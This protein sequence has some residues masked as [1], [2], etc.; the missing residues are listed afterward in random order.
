M[1]ILNRRWDPVTAMASAYLGMA[2]D[3]IQAQV[4]MFTKP[5]EEYKKAQAQNKSHKIEN[6]SRNKQSSEISDS[7]SLQG[8]NDATSRASSMH[9][10]NTYNKKSDTAGLMARA[11]GKS[12]GKMLVATGKG[13]F[14]DVPLAMADGM[15]AMP[16]L[17]GGKVRDYGKVTGW[18]SGMAVGGKAFGL[19]IVD[20][21][22]DLVV[23]PYK[24]GRKEG[25]LG[26]AK[27][28]GKGT[29]NMISKISGGAVGVWAYP[30]QGIA[31]SIS[32]AV[33]TTSKKEIEVAKREEGAWL[34]Q[35]GRLTDADMR[36]MIEAFNLLKR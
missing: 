35:E 15:R 27:G 20:G 5:Y 31:K 25:A 7:Q 22:A 8:G 21:L 29:V 6:E 19:G 11:S 23:Q 30:A 26:V 10:T 33:H 9:S 14:V 2:T 4:G 36:T 13:T 24:G 12:A 32:N 3:I 18:K 28:I 1:Q 34:L 17:Y 16:S